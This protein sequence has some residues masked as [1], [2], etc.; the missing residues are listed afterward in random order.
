MPLTRQAKPATGG[1]VL[2]TVKFGGVPLTVEAVPSTLGTVDAWPWA[3]S[4]KE[5]E[6]EKGKIQGFLELFR[7]QLSRK[8]PNHQSYQWSVF[9][10]KSAAAWHLCSTRYTV[11]KTNLARVSGDM[12]MVTRKTYTQA[13]SLYIGEGSEGLSRLRHQ[14]SPDMPEDNID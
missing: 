5:E 13:E 4:R 1:A 11:F 10:P 6:E 7:S 8:F 3:R 9:S 2:L 14:T 12:C